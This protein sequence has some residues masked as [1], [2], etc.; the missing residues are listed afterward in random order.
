MK[1]C[2]KLVPNKLIHRLD[3]VSNAISF[4]KEPIPVP[5]I[6]GN[7]YEELFQGQV[8]PFNIQIV[9]WMPNRTK[10]EAEMKIRRQEYELHL[11]KLS[12]EKNAINIVQ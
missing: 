1:E 7:P 2:K 11:K 4:F 3:I 6:R 12:K 10:K 8:L 5:P 9:V